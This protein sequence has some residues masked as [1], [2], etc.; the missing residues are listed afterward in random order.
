MTLRI[1][2][3]LLA[4]VTL[5]ILA[6]VA[7]GDYPVG[8]KDLIGL[9]LRPADANPQAWL[10]IVDLRLSRVTMALLV[11]V[12]LGVAGV[13]IQALTRNPLA[14]PGILG[15]N[16]G[17]ALAVTMFIV[18]LEDLPDTLLPWAGFAGAMAASFAVY[19]LAW[20][21]GASSLRLILVGIGLSTL[22]GAATT[23]LTTFAPIEEAQR[24]LIWL[25]GTVYL[26]DWA[27]VRNL[28]LWLTVPLLLSFAMARELDLIR[29]GDQAARSLGQRVEVV[30]AGLLVLASL[31][32]GVAVAAAGPIG[33]VGLIA[34]HIAR[35]LVGP[36]HTR[37]L[38]VAALVGGALLMAADLAGRTVIAPAQLPAGLITALIGAPFLGWLLWGRR[39]VAV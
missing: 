30:R 16:A 9:A 2:A 36:R 12:A 4:L 34:P 6:S 20:R 33:F 29:F 11:G 14:E 24:A 21:N 35:R 26:A 7:I 17:A 1:I 23:L 27:G 31:V 5:I 18:L 37:V 15:I 22:I 39:H 19:A 10:I 8:W 32:C 25:S 38:P 13:V 28:S 3:S